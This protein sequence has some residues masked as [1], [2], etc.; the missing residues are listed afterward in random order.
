MAG[1]EGELA[2]VRKQREMLLESERVA[3]ERNRAL[4]G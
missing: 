3:A 4:A 2:E 1:L